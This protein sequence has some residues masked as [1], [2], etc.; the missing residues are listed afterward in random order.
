LPIQL[1]SKD[2]HGALIHVPMIFA[3]SDLRIV[4]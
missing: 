1:V 2:P 3:H 4:F